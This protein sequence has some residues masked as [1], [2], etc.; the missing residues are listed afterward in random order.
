M[1]P[2]RE[3][4]H[5]RAAR[6]AFLGQTPRERFASFWWA[7]VWAI[8]FRW[9]PP[10]LNAWRFFLLRLFRARIGQRSYIAPSVRIMCPWLLTIGDHVTIAHGVI[11]NCIGTVTIG[12]GTLVSQYAHFCSATHEYTSEAMPITRCPIE[13]GRDVWVAADSFVG[14]GVRLGD[15]CLLAARSSA[16]HDLPVGQVCIGEP[17]R[18]RHA[19]FPEDEAAQAAATRNGP[20]GN[21]QAA[22]RATPKPT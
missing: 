19:R 14:P 7:V 12:D 5:A 2:P 1:A 13:V 8:F 21:G 3:D 17:A 15:R 20:T 11:L 9:S 18:P 16:F 22:P 10:P 6:S 4:Q